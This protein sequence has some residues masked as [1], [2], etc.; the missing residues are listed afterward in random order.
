MPTAAHPDFKKFFALLSAPTGL[1]RV[2][3]SGDVFRISEPKWMSQPYRLTGVGAILTGG[4]WNVRNLIPALNFFT[5]AATANAEADARAIRL[6]WPPSVLIAQTRVAFH[7]SLQAMLDL[8]DPNTLKALKLK[9]TDLVNCDWSAA[10]AA[11]QEALTQAV[12]RAAFETSAEGLI[13]P[14]AQKPVGINVVVFPAHMLP[15][16]AINTH[17]PNA[18]PF[19]HGL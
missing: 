7:L 6:N 11:D 12:A 19:V 16:S 3:W 18:I 13:V 15:G 10:Q 17:Q 5:T 9:K 14:S 1:R 8:T 2:P 4:R